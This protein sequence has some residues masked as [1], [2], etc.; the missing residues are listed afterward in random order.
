[1][2]EH[3]ISFSMAEAGRLEYCKACAAAFDF[4]NSWV[5]TEIWS[6]FWRL[7][8]GLWSCVVYLCIPLVFIEFLISEVGP[9]VSSFA[10]WTK[11]TLSTVWLLAIFC[12][13]SSLMIY[14]RY[15]LRSAIFILDDPWLLNPSSLDPR[16]LYM[17]LIYYICV[18]CTWAFI[19]STL[20]LYK[21]LVLFDDFRIILLFWNSPLMKVFS[22]PVPYVICDE[23]SGDGEKDFM[24]CSCYILIIFQFICKFKNGN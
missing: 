3:S 7:K 22:L 2:D 5:E 16:R 21:F 15:P 13:L 1:M 20:V 14:L 6:P 10:L 9:F 8:S 24:L 19:S 18:H 23:N 12:L 4:L 11:V 17:R